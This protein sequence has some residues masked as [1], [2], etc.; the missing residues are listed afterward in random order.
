MVAFVLPEKIEH[1]LKRR[2][3]AEKYGWRV[4]TVRRRVGQHAKET[5][6]GL[7][8]PHEVLSIL[9]NPCLH[10][11]LILQQFRKSWTV[12]VN[13]QIMQDCKNCHLIK[14]QTNATMNDYFLI[15][16]KFEQPKTC[17]AFSYLG[18]LKR[19]PRSL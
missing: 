5:S 17:F 9:L 2:D 13:R 3:E 10:K 16:N 18:M 12:L 6:G 8:P 14:Q 15:I 19:E 4:A 7:R 11:I 1:D